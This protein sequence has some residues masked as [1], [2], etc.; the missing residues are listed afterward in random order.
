M[1][2]CPLPRAGGRHVGGDDGAV[3]GGAPVAAPAGRAGA[4]A[5]PGI[6]RRGMRGRG[7]AAPPDLEALRLRRGPERDGR[8]SGQVVA[9]ADS[10]RATRCWKTTCRSCPTWAP[11]RRSC[12]DC[13]WPTWNA[14]WWW[15]RAD[16]RGHHQAAPARSPTVQAYLG[17]CAEG[18][19]GRRGSAGRHRRPN[20][21]RG[22]GQPSCGSGGMDGHPRPR[23][24][25]R[26]VDGGAVRPRRRPLRCGDPQ[27]RD[28]RGRTQDG[29]PAPSPQAG[30]PPPVPALAV[31]L[32]ASVLASVARV[33]RGGGQSAVGRGDRRGAVVLRTLPPRHQ[34]PGGEGAGTVDW[35]AGASARS[36]CRGWRIGRPRS[37]T[38]GGH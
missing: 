34:R 35:R 14:T 17:R 5:E 3:P 25:V 1:R 15:R 7:L 21:R 28:H 31:G 30:R 12:P 4:S 8:G 22:G 37:P 6:P 18:G 20:A 33:R 10:P 38:T 11:A 13:H 32:S 9:V 2:Q 24:A 19:H 36:W 23:P 16:R 29:S 26:L 27:R